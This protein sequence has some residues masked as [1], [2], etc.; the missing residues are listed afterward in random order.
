MRVDDSKCESAKTWWKENEIFWENAREM[1]DSVYGRNINMEL[2]SKVDGK[3]LYEILF[4][5]ELD[6]KP[7]E[8]KKVIESFL[9]K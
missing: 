3:R 2:A 6:S 1:W 5:M 8:I 4:E 9:I 7:R